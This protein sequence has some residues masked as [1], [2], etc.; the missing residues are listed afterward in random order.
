M[1][2]CKFLL[3]LASFTSAHVTYAPLYYEADPLSLTILRKN[4]TCWSDAFRRLQNSCDQIDTTTKYKL[5]LDFTNCHL[6]EFNMQDVVVEN[7]FRDET[8]FQIFT[9]F[10]VHV[11]NACHYL[12]SKTWRSDTSRLV[13]EL[14]SSSD[15]LVKMVRFFHDSLLVNVKEANDVIGDVREKLKRHSEEVDS[16]HKKAEDQR[17][18]LFKLLEGVDLFVANI[19]GTWRTISSAWYLVWSLN[20]SYIL[21]SGANIRK[22]RSYVFGLIILEFVIEMFWVEYGYVLR[23]YTAWICILIAVIAPLSCTK[24]VDY[25]GMSRKEIQAV[26]KKKGVKANMSTVKIIESL[27]R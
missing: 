10:F 11:D 17:A 27:R 1:F 26:A 4:T 12:E 8:A 5:S 22:R 15:A 18:S 6:R 19:S 23:L 9:Q 20:V 3:A 13:G 21:T 2:N 24:K 16:S 14:Y 25:S 7:F